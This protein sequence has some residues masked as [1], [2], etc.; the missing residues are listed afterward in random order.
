M[1]LT[2]QRSNGFPYTSPVMADKKVTFDYCHQSSLILF[3]HKEA[4][5]P[6]KLTQKGWDATEHQTTK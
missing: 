4:G 1:E 2:N 5:F 6:H 3:I